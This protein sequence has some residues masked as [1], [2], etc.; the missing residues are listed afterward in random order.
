MTRRRLIPL[1]V[2][3]VGLLLVGSW[4]YLHEKIDQ[5]CD[6]MC[7]PIEKEAWRR[8]VQAGLFYGAEQR[9][10]LFEMAQDCMQHSCAC[11]AD[12]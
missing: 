4:P 6:N 5:H 10:K 9:E 2:V 11:P 8:G 1:I 3:V 12:E 7:E